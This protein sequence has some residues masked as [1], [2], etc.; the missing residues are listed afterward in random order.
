MTFREG[1]GGFVVVERET[2]GRRRQGGDDLGEGAAPGDLRQTRIECLLGAGDQMAAPLVRTPER[3]VRIAGLAFLGR[4]EMHRSHAQGSRFL[5]NFPRRLW[6]RQADDERDRIK[7]RRRGT[8]DER[9]RERLSADGDKR[10]FAPR[11]IDEAG[12]EGVAFAPAQH[13]EQVRRPRIASRQ[14]S[15]DFGQLE[16]DDV[17]EGIVLVLDVLRIGAAERMRERE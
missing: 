2:G 17:H 12:I 6:A 11:P 8:P 9:K 4:D 15:P 13:V 16:E 5:E 10:A 1:R 3:A 14:G 7:R